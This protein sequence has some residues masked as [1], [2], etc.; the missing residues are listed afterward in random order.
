MRA[1]AKSRFERVRSPVAGRP[2]TV[3]GCDVH[4]SPTRNRVTFAGMT[5][6]RVP[7]SR[8]APRQERSRA[9]VE[10]ILDATADVLRVHGLP[11]ATVARIAARAGVSTGSLYQYFPD[12]TALYRALGER[13]F[14]RIEAASDQLWPHLQVLPLPDAIEVAVRGIAAA[15]FVDPVLDRILHQVAI[16]R[17]EGEPVASFEA[18]QEARVATFL[19][20]RRAELPDPSLDVEMTA[21]LLSRALGGIVGSTCA[22]EPALAADPRFVDALVRFALRTLGFPPPAVQ[23]GRLADTSDRAPR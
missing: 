15:A 10:A 19:A 8:R 5:T 4:V 22:R 9:L 2:E 13:F 17:M 21:R 1:A 6:S 16:S 20:A 11:G 14:R 7:P 23:T 18:G 12:K 3:G